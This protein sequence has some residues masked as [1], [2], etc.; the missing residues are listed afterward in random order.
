MSVNLAARRPRAQLRGGQSV[1]TFSTYAEAQRTVDTLSDADF[2]V[3]H[4]Q[5]VGHDL[6]LVESI[7]GRLTNARAAG[8]G[9]VSGAWFGLFIGLLVGLFTT[10]PTWLGLMVGGALIGAAWGAIFGFTAHWA[11]RGTRDFSSLT[12]LVAS[13]Y[14]VVVED[15]YAAAARRILTSESSDVAPG[16]SRSTTS[17]TPAATD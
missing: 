14:D 9:A 4:A 15:E 16:L 17:D 1:A 8:A 10:G 2:P 3:E 13:H 6:N 12:A 5:V 11:T 7:T